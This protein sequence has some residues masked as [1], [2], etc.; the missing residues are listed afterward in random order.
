MRLILREALQ[1]KGDEPVEA[2]AR[3][4]CYV[5]QV[6]MVQVL[7]K[8]GDLDKRLDPLMLFLALLAVTVGP[9]QLP[10]IARLVGPAIEKAF[11][12]RWE[13]FLGVPA[14]KLRPSPESEPDRTLRRPKPASKQPS[15]R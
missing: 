13:S 4:A 10:Q 15:R 8:S 3:S 2:A 1:D 14:D 9:A 12:K 7:Q 5:R 6:A 11:T